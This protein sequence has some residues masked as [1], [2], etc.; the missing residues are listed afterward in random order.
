MYAEVV[1]EEKDERTPPL[2]PGMFVEA[3]IA[4]PTLTGALLVPRGCVRRGRVYV[5]DGGVAHER[6]VVVER[7][8]L[9]RT[10]VSGLEPGA[11]VITSN[12]DVLAEGLPVTPVQSAARPADS[13]SP[14]ATKQP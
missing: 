11:L 14:A 10:V 6:A 5:C 12:L 9:D 8:I 1:N 4:G 2:M 13:Q 3:H 7:Q